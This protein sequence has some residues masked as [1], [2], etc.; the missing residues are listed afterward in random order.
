MRQR[1]EY[2]LTFSSGIVTS[3]DGTVKF[4]LLVSFVAVLKTMRSECNKPLTGVAEWWLTP[5][6]V[7]AVD[8]QASAV[9]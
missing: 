4:N 1:A 5:C 8:C 3:K 6:F 2:K 7:S 9:T